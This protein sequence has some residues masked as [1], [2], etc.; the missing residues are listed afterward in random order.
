MS[1]LFWTKKG[2]FFTL[3]AASLVVVI[4][5]SFSVYKK[6]E[7]K[8]DIETIGIR[9]NT[10]NNFIKDVEQDLEKGL[11][12]ASFRAF[13]GMSQYIASNGSYINDLKGNFNS[14]ILDGTLNSQGIS[15]MDEST[16]T[17]WTEK[18]EEQAD[19]IGVLANFTIIDVE[20]NQTTP[21]HVDVKAY[22][23]I[24]IQDKK[25]T[26]MW[27]RSRNITTKVSL[28]NLEDPLYIIGS[29]GR[30]TTPIIES[31]ISDFVTGGDV[32]N[33]MTHA[34]NSYYKASEMSPNFLMRLQGD[35]SNSSTGIESLVNVQELTD[36]GLAAK[37]RSIVDYIYFGSQATTNYRINATPLWFKID[38]AHLAAYEV[39]NLT[40]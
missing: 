30:V 7:M 3:A 10:M 40:I 35:F 36:Q 39:Q 15:L 6:Y 5:L 17:D 22:I 14:L 4:L 38:S 8:E 32:T 29:K 23:N 25:N 16:F 37:D 33:L 2:I 31:P 20:I 21:W 19:K 28:E 13:T 18:I 12:I 9:I 11:Y 34:N 1:K 24:T 26:S 27:K